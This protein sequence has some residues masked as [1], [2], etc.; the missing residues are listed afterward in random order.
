MKIRLPMHPRL[1]GWFQLY[2]FLAKCRWAIFVGV[3]ALVL[4]IIVAMMWPVGSRIWLILNGMILVISLILVVRDWRDIARRETDLYIVNVQ[5]RTILSRIQMSDAYSCW[6]LIEFHEQYAIYS[7]EV[8]KLLCTTKLDTKIVRDKYHISEPV[9]TLAP[10]ILRTE[11]Q[12]GA[13]IF[14]SSKVRLMTDII[15]ETFTKH[16][17]VS[18]QET[19]YFSSICTN[20]MSWK[21]VISRS[22]GT[23]ILDGLTLISN[24]RILYDYAESPC[25]NHIGMGTLAFT[26]DGK[27]ITSI[28][29]YESA[30]S[31]GF[32]M[33]SGTGSADWSDLTP[34]I[35]LQDFVTRA[36]E[37]ELLEECGLRGRPVPVVTEIVGFVRHVNRGYKPDFF[38]VSLIGVS[39]NE[40]RIAKEER[41]FIADIIATKVTKAT[42]EELG[43]ALEQFRETHEPTFS[44]V[45]Y[46]NLCFLLSRLKEDKNLFVK[47]SKALQSRNPNTKLGSSN[48][49]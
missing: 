20:E 11:F 12:R 37:R 26:L 2:T 41:W 36:M 27:M 34:G 13:A 9:R 14:N 21:Q 38:G 23:V 47:L 29:T 42:A 49:R 40:L 28:Q 30:Q 46:L 22:R 48:M 7:D 25:S 15:K 43:D 19:D 31:P 1:K 35:S 33:P 5:P 16:L 32:M 6:Q 8:N 17:P 3:A 4:G 10:F 18:L 45:L 44:I 24:K 39:S